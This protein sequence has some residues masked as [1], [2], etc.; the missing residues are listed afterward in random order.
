MDI[1][2]KFSYYS[3]VDHGQHR[4]DSKSHFNV[5][6]GQHRSDGSRHSSPGL[7]HQDRTGENHRFSASQDSH[8]NDALR[9]FS[10]DVNHQDRTGENH[11]FSV[12]HGQRWSDALRHF[13]PA[14][15][16]QSWKIIKPYDADKSRNYSCIECLQPLILKKGDVIAPYFSHKTDTRCEFFNHT[17]ESDEHRSAKIIIKSFFD[18]RMNIE[19]KSCCDLCGFTLSESMI[20]PIQS[21]NG[22]FL[23]TPFNVILEYSIDR[24]WIA[25][26]AVPALGIIIEVFHTHKTESYR[27]GNWYEVKA[28]EVLSQMENN[29]LSLTNIRKIKCNYCTL[30]PPMTICPRCNDPVS[31][32]FV[33]SFNQ[34][35]E[36]LEQKPMKRKYRK[37][38]RYQY[39][40]LCKC[41]TRSKIKYPYCKHFRCIACFES[42]KQ[43]PY[44]SNNS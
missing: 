25:D 16:S 10:P 23:F 29:F 22:N 34:C 5:D 26:L 28:S 41:K 38:N 40:C 43:C 14:Y 17:G 20:Y 18:R 13:K 21:Y 15:D 6:H 36:C 37:K 24:T 31:L 12:D 32:E 9:H 39:C 3:G 1:N 4:S 35:S 11:R 30:N 8:T 27:P 33:K 42:G 19:M 7:N 44:C 2:E